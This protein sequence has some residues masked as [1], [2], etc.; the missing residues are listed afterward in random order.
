M[1]SCTVSKTKLTLILALGVLL[2]VC[3]KFVKVGGA[4][5]SADPVNT[6][7]VEGLDLSSFSKDAPSHPLNLVFL[8]HS[9]GGQLLA[10]SGSDEG[11]KP[12]SAIY[13]SHPC[14]GGLRSALIGQ[15]YS[16]H[17]ASYGSSLGEHT[18]L[19]DWLPKFRDRMPDVLSCAGQDSK[20]EGESSNAIVVFKS[21]FPN[22]EFVGPGQDPGD[23]NGKQLT[24]ANA[25]ATLRALLPEF[26]KHPEVLFVYVTAPPMA[27]KTPAR[28]LF[29]ALKDTLRGK[30]SPESRRLTGSRLAREFNDWVYNREGWLA[31]YP[32]K[33]VV[34]FNYYQILTADG[35][36]NLSRFCAPNGLDS[37]PNRE[38]NAMAATEFTELL[39]RAVHRSGLIQD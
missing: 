17:E 38:G 18:D 9:C 3:L 27:P 11:S 2:V 22:N 26:K 16:V 32:A 8:H 14:G 10:D 35:A 7:P 6:P 30:A 19:F 28:N 25:K 37:H 24:V 1:V 23:A 29:G 5:L 4:D 13:A 36:S 39:N 20:L 33:N 34:V 21:C 15:G 12:G 31:N